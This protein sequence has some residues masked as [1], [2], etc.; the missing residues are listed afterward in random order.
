MFALLEQSPNFFSNSSFLA[1]FNLNSNIILTLITLNKVKFNFGRVLNKTS[2][3]KNVNL[4][5][6][7]SGFRQETCRWRELTR[8]RVARQVDVQVS[9]YFHGCVGR[10][11]KCG[12]IAVGCICSVWAEPTKSITMG[13]WMGRLLRLSSGCFFRSHFSLPESLLFFFSVTSSVS[14]D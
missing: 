9:G 1:Q 6:G 5:H 4:S 7:K 10:G 14:S 3:V 13:L 12:P 11:S 2:G 8:V